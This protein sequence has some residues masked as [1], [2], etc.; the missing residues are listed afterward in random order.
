MFLSQIKKIEKKEIVPVA[1]S[2]TALITGLMVSIL[3]P[4]KNN[5]GILLTLLI[6]TVVSQL[7]ILLKSVTSQ[8]RFF[9]DE[10]LLELINLSSD[11][12]VLLENE[13][14]VGC[15]DS[16]QKL[17]GFQ[18]GTKI[19]GEYL[20][21]ILSGF[22][23]DTHDLSEKTIWPLYKN[24]DRGSQQF[25]WI[26][27]RQDKTYFPAEIK[28]MQINSKGKILVQGIIRDLTEDKKNE[29]IIKKSFH[30]IDV[31]NTQLRILTRA[32]EYSANSV[33]IT[34]SK[35][36]IE[37]V[38]PKFL[39]VTGFDKEDVIGKTSSILK[40]GHQDSAFYE[41]L[42]KTILGGK[43]WWG[44]F[45]NKRKDG[46]TFWE[47]ATIAPVF[48]EVGT[49][50]HFIAVKEDITEKKQAL[51][52]I[53][54]Q[55][56]L[57]QSVLDAIPNPL[58]FINREGVYTG[59]NKAFEEH[60]GKTKLELIGKTVAVF[61]WENAETFFQKD[62]ELLKNPGKQHYESQIP[63]KNGVFH[64]VVFYRAVF[65]GSDGKI[66]GLVGV[67]LD[68]TDRKV[69]ESSLRASLYDLEK[70]NHKLEKMTE[71]AN[72]MAKKAEMANIAKSAFLANMSHE[73][74]TPMNAVVGMTS[75]LMSTELDE[76]QLR[77]LKIVRSSSE[78]LLNLINDILDISKIE[79]GKI[80]L[81]HIDFDLHVSL[82]DIREL[83]SVKANEKNLEFSININPDVPAL[84]NG[85]PG[86][87][88]QILVN[89]LGNAIKF[90]N[91]GSVSLF[92]ESIEMQ[93]NS[94]M[95]KF[96]ISDTG[97]G[98]PEDRLP[99]LFSIFTQVDGSITRKYGGTGLGLSIAKRL[100]EMMGGSIGVC[101]KIGEG[102]EFWFT[103]NLDL[104]K[105]DSLSRRITRADLDG[106][107]ILIVDDVETNRYMLSGI[108]SKRNCTCVS[109]DDGEKAMIH[110]L[111]AAASQYPFQV[112]LIDYQMPDMDGERL[113]KVI[114]SDPAINTT[115]CILLTSDEQRGD[116]IRMKKAGFDGYL[117]KPID[118]EL[119]VECVSL[120]L[121]KKADES[122]LPIITRHTI[123]EN[124][125]K[126]IRILVV[127]DLST[128][129]ELMKEYLELL[130]YSAQS[131]SNGM[132]AIEILKQKE[133]DLIL[134][135]IQMPV[136]DGLKATG[137]IRDP[138]SNVLNHGT[139]IIA[140]TAN[141]MA[142]D[143]EQ[144]LNSGMNDYICK[145]IRLK[146]LSMILD[147]YLSGPTMN[148][149]SGYNEKNNQ[150]KSD[151]RNMILEKDVVNKLK[152][153]KE[154]VKLQKPLQCN[155]IISELKEMRHS[156]EYNKYLDSIEKMVN[157][158]QF[159]EAANK[160][161]ELTD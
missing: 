72:D 35:G 100:A 122:D 146:N 76:K 10:W 108:L 50:T 128:N 144:C 23:N 156:E 69:F 95:F 3:Y 15:N 11:P 13:I 31:Q 17:F 24:V 160:I 152:E 98:I 150:T 126:W 107:K 153:L 62:L 91:S 111:Q 127:E 28:L 33:V 99:N 59:C 5:D 43:E 46:S 90:T 104:Q 52:I 89:L 54:S 87:L 106:T 86:K 2:V 101:S 129:Q 114:K 49:I 26:C 157:E 25:E 125:K 132:E 20:A 130:G 16:F 97:I 64:D 51:D 27:K 112:A 118:T 120:V 14:I 133:Y 73:I 113:C 139:I 60:L 19:K 53:E 79:A 67:I 39:S 102:S 110:L 9:N 161:R 29:K 85:D 149:L 74:R 93:K 124:G 40:S 56:Q 142:G 42:W 96:I 4:G 78:E 38:N 136:M 22:K 148:A 7:H 21:E 140:M 1:F 135:D 77:Y 82:Q 158:Y 92:V 55:L 63:F 119:L 123:A 41:G 68:I 83:L 137:V 131:A 61:G 94:G 6:V 147:K 30:Q 58:Y 18:D 88:R 34:D 121:G 84:L 71:I 70:T 44:E 57:H 37:Y 134:M 151:A 81:D 47:M 8:K 117:V 80:S 109:V 116:A 145:P 45:N 141:A 105:R 154:L 48:D 75:L 155:R 138:H 66:E 36:N 115:K 12:L 32:I 65:N 103:C 143:K 159:I